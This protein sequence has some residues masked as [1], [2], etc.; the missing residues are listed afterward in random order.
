MVKGSITKVGITVLLLFLTISWLGAHNTIYGHVID[1]STGEVMTGVTVFIPKL[2]KGTLTDITGTFKFNDLNEGEY[3]IT[4][5]FLG[6]VTQN[7]I[8]SA[9]IPVEIPLETAVLNLEEIVVS[10]QHDLSNTMNIINKIDLELRPIHSSQDIL[11]MIPGLF[12][13]Q[14]AGGGK[15]EQIYLRGFDIDHGTD[16]RVSVDGMPVNMVS[17]AHGQ[18]Y[19]DLHFLI[20]E[21]IDHI[22][23]DKG[24]YTLNKVILPR[25]VTPILIP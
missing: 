9:G 11:R 6:Y 4:I 10:N 2:Q 17:H 8:A 18:G 12:T 23:F 3:A 24:P 19:A 1:A 13:A 21:L 20:P 14:H 22:D 7:V 25:Q 16:I 5:S 15:A